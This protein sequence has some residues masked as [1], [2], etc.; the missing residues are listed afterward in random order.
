MAVYALLIGAVIV[1][2]AIVFVDFLF[3][4]LRASKSLHKILIEAVLGTT[5]R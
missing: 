1:I 4:S 2:Y 3:G 5:W